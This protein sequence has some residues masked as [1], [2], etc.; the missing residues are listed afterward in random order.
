[1]SEVE[2]YLLSDSK[3]RQR[4]SATEFFE[5]QAGSSFLDEAYA[6]HK[7]FLDI[8]IAASDIEKAMASI[9][10]DYNYGVSS[11]WHEGVSLNRLSITFISLLNLITSYHDQAKRICVSGAGFEV[12]YECDV[13]AF[14]SKAYDEH[15]EYRLLEKLRNVVQHGNREIVKVWFAVKNALD[16]SEQQA[17]SVLLRSKVSDLLVHRQQ[18]KHRVAKDLDDLD[19]EWIDLKWCFRKYV[20]LVAECHRD[21]MEKISPCFYKACT[22]KDDL[23]SRLIEMSGKN[24]GLCLFIGDEVGGHDGAFDIGKTRWFFDKVDWENIVIPKAGVYYSSQSRFDRSEF[25]APFLQ[26]C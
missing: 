16:G 14:Y 3:V 24:H 6:F 2:A 5:L 17:R 26:E 13:K 1:M 19:F 8:C 18:L 12:N 15:F 25:S 9:A 7:R 23:A 4:L 20:E 10:F 22:I 21:V 11:K